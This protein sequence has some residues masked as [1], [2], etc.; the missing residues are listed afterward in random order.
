MLSDAAVNFLQPLKH[1][2]DAER[3]MSMIPLGGIYWDDEIPDFREL[4]TL[5]KDDR[6]SIFR[7]FSIRF[8]LWAGDEL[9]A[10]DQSYWESAQQL[11]PNYPL[12]RRIDLSDDDRA[13][14]LQAEQETMAGF[15]A[16]IGDADEVNVSEDGSWSAT[17]DLTKD[18]PSLWQRFL[19]W[20][21]GT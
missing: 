20:C 11:V 8:K 5:H 3:F 10:V 13:A 21:R 14:Q 19:A 18:Q 4:M 12:F 16:L 6:D 17:F 15:E 7:L 9:D 1:N 2:P